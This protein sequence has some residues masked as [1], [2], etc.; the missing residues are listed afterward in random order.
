MYVPL[1]ISIVAN[2][3]LGALASG[4]FLLAIIYIFGSSLKDILLGGLILVGI[5]L[6]VVFV[7][8]IIYRICKKKSSKAPVHADT[9][10]IFINVIII[11][12]IFIILTASFFLF[13]DIWLLIN[14]WWF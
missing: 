4:P 8:Y 7:N 2:T 5:I 11:I 10:K 12:G 6:A 1:W 9:K 13:P 3:I 14:D